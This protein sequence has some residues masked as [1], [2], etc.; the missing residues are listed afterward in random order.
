LVLFFF[1][2]RD[3]MSGKACDKCG[4]PFKGFGTTCSTCRKGGKNQAKD[5]DK[6]GNYFIGHGTI[7]EDCKTGKGPGRTGVRAPTPDEVDACLDRIDSCIQKVDASQ[8][9]MVRLRKAEFDLLGQLEIVR[10]IMTRVMKSGDRLLLKNT[11]ADCGRVARLAAFLKC[12]HLSDMNASDQRFKNCEDVLKSLTDL[13]S[14]D[15]GASE[16]LAQ[17]EESAQSGLLMKRLSFL[18]DESKVN[19]AQAAVDQGPADPPASQSGGRAAADHGG[20]SS[21]AYS[22]SYH[23]GYSNYSGYYGGGGSGYAGGGGGYYGSGYGGGG[24]YPEGDYAQFDDAEDL[25]DWEDEDH[26]E[27][28]QEMADQLFESNARILF[29]ELDVNK[30]GSLTKDEVLNGASGLFSLLKACRIHKRKHVIKMFKDGDLDNNGSL[31]FNEFME[32]IK[33]A[34]Q[35]SLASQPKQIDDS[36]VQKVFALM[37]RDGDGSI[38]REEL[39]LAYAGVLLMAGE[40]VDSKRISKWASRNFKKYDADGSGTIDLQEFKQLLTHSGALAPMLDFADSM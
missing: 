14:S 17:A 8:H 27:M 15:L 20:Y 30:D 21:E 38:T 1:A 22:S 9:S 31:D 33:L 5:C 12:I 10:D 16:Q 40:M 6:C 29:E 7:C 37:D 26:E 32:Y 18:M 11:F 3:H 24:G 39:K 36:K 34:R 13:V 23:G 2:P 4:Q 25:S 19:E 28:P 35:K